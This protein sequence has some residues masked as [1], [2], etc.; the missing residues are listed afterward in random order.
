VA[1]DDGGGCFNPSD[2]AE[3]VAGVCGDVGKLLAVGT[4][5]GTNGRLE[6]GGLGVPAGGQPSIGQHQGDHLRRAHQNIA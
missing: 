4:Q 1:S 2:G 6:T 3:T 5:S